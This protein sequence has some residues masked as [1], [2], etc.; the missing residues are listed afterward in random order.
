LDEYLGRPHDPNQPPIVQNVQ[1]Y[2]LP[3][4]LQAEVTT[5][6]EIELDRRQFQAGLAF[7]R[8]QPKAWLTLLGQK[9]VG[10]LWFR[11]DIGA[12]YD[13]SW[14]VYYKP[15]YVT[16]LILTIAGLAIST[17]A[18]R[19][20][21]L[22]YLLFVFY[23]AIHIAYNVQS[24]YRWEIEPFFLIFAALCV[25]EVFDRLSA[26]RKRRKAISV[27]PPSATSENTLAT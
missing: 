13:A 1:P 6:S 16:L 15:L 18:W 9:A 24:R 10:F 26:A 22:L 14:V 25:V 2:P 23:T 5:I 19:R 27:S 7:I 8:Q 4:D 20:Y 3:P 12:L 17:R 21:S 11:R